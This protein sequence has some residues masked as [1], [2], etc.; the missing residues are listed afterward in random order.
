MQRLIARL[1][2]TT[3][4][5]W[6]YGLLMAVVAISI[7]L[8]IESLSTA[9][10]HALQ[11]DPSRFVRAPLEV[12]PLRILSAVLVAPVVETFFIAWTTGLVKNPEQKMLKI[13]VVSAIVWG[14][15]HATR[16]LLEFLPTAWDF[17]CMTYA[18][19]LWRR[20]SLKHAYIVALIP[21]VLNNTLA[22]A[23]MS[24]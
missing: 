7:S 14:A 19:V 22:I 1:T 3:G 13:A 24:L 23:L 9:I 2:S 17:F 8:A 18:F 10:L 12:T 5:V 11:I 21:H 4:S 6:T 20:K 16:G 15:L